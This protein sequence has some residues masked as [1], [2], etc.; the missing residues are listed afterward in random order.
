M[1]ADR[2]L[3]VGGGPAGV[4]AALQARELGAQGTPL[5]AGQVGGPSLN[6]GPAP[7]RT[8]ARAARLARDGSSW[9]RFGLDGPAPVPDLPAVLANSERVA[10]YA[11]EKKDLAGHLRRHGIDLIEGLGPVGFADP[12]TLTAGP[13]T[14]S[15]DRII[16]AVGGPAGRAGSRSSAA[17]TP[18]AR[19]RRSSTTSAP[20]LPCSRPGRPWSRRPTRACRPSSSGPS[21]PGAWTCTPARWSRRSVPAATATAP[22]ASTT[23]PARSPAT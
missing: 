14:W 10:R 17:P 13:R 23:G 6:R 1:S 3:V 4:N 19:S 18:A 8:L 22:S 20:P 11:H 2:L 15:A 12:H 5:E 16:V 9:P 7:V 21:A